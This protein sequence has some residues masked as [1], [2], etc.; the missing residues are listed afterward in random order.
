MW[1]FILRMT[2]AL[3][4][5]RPRMWLPHWLMVRLGRVTAAVAR[6]SGRPTNLTPYKACFP[7]LCVARGG[8]TQRQI[9][10]L[11]RHHFYNIDKARRE[12]GYVPQVAQTEALRRTVAYFREQPPKA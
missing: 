9:C 1:E 7:S 4:V 10:V 2:D 6:I 12:L 5:T 8:L 11:T 3:G